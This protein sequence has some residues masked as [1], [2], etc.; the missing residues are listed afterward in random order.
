MA[1]GPDPEQVPV[2]TTTYFT[3]TPDGI[4]RAAI[5]VSVVGAERCI[6]KSWRVR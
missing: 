6:D 1:D 4:Y 5:E 3:A 2:R